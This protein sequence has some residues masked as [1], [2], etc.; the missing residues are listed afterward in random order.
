MDVVEYIVEEKHENVWVPVF[1]T[2]C[3][4]SCQRFVLLLSVPHNELRITENKIN[5]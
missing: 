3:L 1:Y 4:R 5:R 2:D